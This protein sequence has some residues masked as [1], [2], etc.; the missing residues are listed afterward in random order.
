M[1]R[2]L[3][4]IARDRRWCAALDIPCYMPRLDR[5][6]PFGAIIATG[7]L[8]DCKT[9]TSFSAAYLDREYGLDYGARWT[10]RML[11]DYSPGRYGLVI[12]DVRP[13]AVPIPFTSR[14]GKLIPI[15]DSVLVEVLAP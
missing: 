6:L 15:P 11:G 12:R 2:E 9:T 3:A 1:L 5:A 8:T 13:L 4:D 14:Q 10:E 7:W